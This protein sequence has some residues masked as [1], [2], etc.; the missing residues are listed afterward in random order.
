MRG[1]QS[2]G[3]VLFHIP[4]RPLMRSGWCVDNV[5]GN[6]EV[7]YMNNIEVRR[8][9]SKTKSKVII[10]Y[11]SVFLRVITVFYSITF[12]LFYFQ[13]ELVVTHNEYCSLKILLQFRKLIRLSVEI[14]DLLIYAEPIA[15]FCFELFCFSDWHVFRTFICSLSS[16]YNC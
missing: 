2:R 6:P 8:D 15:I 11:S 14:F 4:S 9:F 12:E 7:S 3:T 1:N 5:Y 16:S 10:K 13:I